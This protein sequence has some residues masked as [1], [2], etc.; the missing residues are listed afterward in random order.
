MYGTQLAE[1]M[2][3]DLANRGLIIVSGLARASTPLLTTELLLLAERQSE[4]WER[5][6]MSAT[7]R[8][9]RNYLKRF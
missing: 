7:P 9:T 5:E 4:S 2:G 1:R 8:R 6:S 3:R